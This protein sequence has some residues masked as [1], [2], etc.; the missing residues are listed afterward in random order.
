MSLI[1][2]A[3]IAATDFLVD[4]RTEAEQ[5]PELPQ[6]MRHA[7]ADFGPHGPKPQQNQR[8]VLACRSGIRAWQAAERLSQHW[9][10]EIKLLAL[11]D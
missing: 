3:D 8:A 11:G 9:N 10:G 6:A 1:A 7:V 4:L 5:G 2:P